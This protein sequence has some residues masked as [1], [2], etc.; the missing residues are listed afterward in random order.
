MGPDLSS[1]TFW[2]GFNREK[3][4]QLKAKIGQQEG[5]ITPSA[6]DDLLGNSKGGRDSMRP[7]EEQK[8][9][10]V[11]PALKEALEKETNRDIVTGCIVALAKIGQ[12]P[13]QCID[14]FKKFFNSKDQEIAETAVLAL[15]ILAA[16]E[17]LPILKEFYTDSDKARQ[18]TGGREVHWR[19]RTFAGYGIGLV[20]ARTADEAVRVEAQKLLLEFLAGEGSKRA[21][22]KDLRVATVISLGLI[23]DPERKAVQALQ[24]YFDENRAKEERICAH[25]PNAI[26]RL[27]KDAPVNERGVYVQMCVAELA[28]KGKAKDSE[29][30][31]SMAQAIGMLTKADDPFAKKAFEVIQD[32]IE[33]ELSKNNLLA[34]FGMIALGQISGTDKPGNNIE[35]YLLTKAQASGGRVMTRAWGALALGVAGFDQAN[36]KEGA[37]K[38][39]DAVG[40]ALLNMM[41]TEIKDPEQ[42]GAYAIG[43]GLMRYAP[44]ADQ[45]RKALDAVKDDSY[46]GY[47]ATALGLMNEKGSI[48]KIR[49]MVKN[50]TRR[51]E[52][53]RECA[54]ALGLLGDK[55]VV[56]ILLGIL[57]DKE[58]KVLAVQAAVATALGY[59]GDYRS[60]EPKSGL[61]AML[62]DEKKELS[63][64]SR[65]FAAVAMG[66]V[67]D[68][69]DFP[70]NFKVSTDINYTSTVETLND[71]GSQTGLLNLL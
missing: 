22:T 19:T 32:K 7:S 35:K 14:V 53:L 18:W 36:R 28:E 49:D 4:L 20:G 34:Y 51:P 37:E 64:E 24:K 63:M 27:L 8:A 30:R 15:G 43:L 62:R 23:T 56:K 3:Y 47:F 45:L 65:A 50:A 33:N 12:E 6:G 71:Q 11:V 60:I 66:I 68:K 25:I 13:Q 39:S 61:P 41:K 5:I 44:A 69:E 46:R 54:I 38:P 21:A 48:D 52:L 58:N 10:D 29:I 59:I 70:W 1:W 2:W 9:R 26:G 40:E 16:P 57:G 55:D 67:C 31:R 17:G 42:L